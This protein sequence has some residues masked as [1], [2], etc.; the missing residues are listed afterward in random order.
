MRLSLFP[1]GMLPFLLGMVVQA[2][3]GRQN[4]KRVQRSRSLF[5]QISLL[6]VL[7]CQLGLF[8]FPG[9]PCYFRNC[10]THYFLVCW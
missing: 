1:A 7:L 5:A 8:R 4:V 6:Q 3:L 2:N 9:S 10:V